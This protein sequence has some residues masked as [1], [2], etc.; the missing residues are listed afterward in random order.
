MHF[1][2]KVQRHKNLGVYAIGKLLDLKIFFFADDRVD[3][4]LFLPRIAPLR[5]VQRRAAINF[6]N[7][8]LIDLLVFF[9]VDSDAELPVKACNQIV[10]DDGVYHDAEIKS[11]LTPP[12]YRP[13]PCK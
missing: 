10:N 6:I 4:D 5:I 12:V 3:D 8:V 11:M 2:D 13:S 7:N 1:T 9:T